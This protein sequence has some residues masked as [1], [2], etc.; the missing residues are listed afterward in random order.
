MNKKVNIKYVYLNN[1]LDV[2]DA[3]REFYVYFERPGTDLKNLIDFVD[4]SNYK[5]LVNFVKSPANRGINR[6][7]KFKKNITD[8]CDNI[9]S[10][11]PASF[12][13]VKSI[14]LKLI[15]LNEAINF[16]EQYHEEKSE[17]FSALSVGSDS[18]FI[19]FQSSNIFKVTQFYKGKRKVLFE[20]DI[21]EWCETFIKNSYIYEKD[22]KVLENFVKE[23][24]SCP[25][26]IE[27]NIRGSFRT[28][29]S[30]I[31]E[32]LNFTGIRFVNYNEISIVGKMMILENAAKVQQAK[33]IIEE[34]QIDPL[35]KVYNKK[36]ITSFIKEIIEEDKKENVA[37]VIMDL[38]HFKPV[39]DVYGHLEGDKVLER[40]GEILQEIVGEQG[41]VGRYG[42][43][44]FILLIYD[45]TS[46]LILRGFLRSIL[47]KIRNAFAD[48]YDDINVTCSVGCSVYPA[49][50]EDYDELFRKADFCLYRAKDKG[51]NRYVFFRDD[52]HLEIYKKAVG[53]T[54]GLKYDERE[55]LEL[56]YMSEFMTELARSPFV[57]I[58]RILYHML[59]TYNLDNISIYYG[60][61]MKQIYSCGKELPG[62]KNA[63]YVNLPNFKSLLAGKFYYRMDFLSL[64][65]ETM[66]DFKK[67]MEKRKIKSSVQCV[68]GTPECIK[69]LVTFNRMRES[70]LWAEY[71]VNCTTMFVSTLNILPESVK[72][73]FALYNKEN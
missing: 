54:K 62:L 15:D 30:E 37:L 28:C 6:V 21:D 52:L 41:I 20:Q 23:L 64:I 38:D 11:Y 57:A 60:E 9:V 71:E 72:V 35:T 42:G 70:S 56:K 73:D 65:P 24:K 47:L 46:E 7:F 26:S 34:I 59:D 19:Y 48:S 32:S 55:V 13:N 33:K 3:N 18:V 66:E 4:S 61:E 17:L 5:S 68:L 36:T 25:K 44:E 22:V 8:V 67:E 12:N 16:F 53:V 14:C 10:I 27:A 69:G 45:V 63:K 50:G 58:Q 2:L 51:R 43:D 29:N 40:T 31:K 49:N 39:N 1:N